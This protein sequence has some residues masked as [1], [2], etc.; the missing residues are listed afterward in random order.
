[1]KLKSRQMDLQTI[2]ILILTGLLAGT[3]GGLVGIGGGIIIVPALIY[4]LGFS[5]WD[6]QGTSLALLMFPVGVLGVMQYYK[7]GHVH[8]GYVAF[9]AVGFLLGGYLG[10][11]IS[12]S[13]PQEH[14][15][16]FFAVFMILIALKMLF[17]DS[18]PLPP[19]ATAE[20]LKSNP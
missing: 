10:S 8:F 14:V 2:I 7:Q 12:L 5:Q 18:K 16:R 4:F 3:L 17:F 6:A 20:K 1:M 15:K 9:I 11:K 13:I 19:K